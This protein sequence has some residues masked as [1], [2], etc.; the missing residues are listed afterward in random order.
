MGGEGGSETSKW[1]PCGVSSFLT[2]G[3]IQP[4]SIEV[5]SV[6]EEVANG[7]VWI[8]KGVLNYRET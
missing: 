1:T 2:L 5:Q 4:G 8:L 7:E 6:A 3:K